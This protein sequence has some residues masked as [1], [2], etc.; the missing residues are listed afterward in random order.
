M[1]GSFRMPAR[2]SLLYPQEKTTLYGVEIPDS[3]ALHQPA[4]QRYGAL[5]VCLTA[6]VG[7]L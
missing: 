1:L 3:S 2:V 4:L 6:V 7:F 5:R